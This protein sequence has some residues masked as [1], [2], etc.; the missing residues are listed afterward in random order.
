[1]PGAADWLAAFWELCTDRQIGMA[2]GDIPAAS[3]DRVAREYGAEAAD[4]RH[5]I[6]AMDRT[7]R[8]AIE[9]KS[10]PPTMDASRFKEMFGR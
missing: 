1:M 9:D 3:I 8:Q 10:K 4:F 5:C 2:M 7:W 6:R